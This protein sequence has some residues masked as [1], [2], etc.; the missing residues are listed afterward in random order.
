[1]GEGFKKRALGL[2]EKRA[3]GKPWKVEMAGSSGTELT[4]IHRHS[5]EFNFIGNVVGPHRV[6]GP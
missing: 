4:G 3:S 1:M 6:K 5:T 2:Q